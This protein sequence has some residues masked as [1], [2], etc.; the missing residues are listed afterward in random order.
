MN[1]ISSY[2]LTKNSEKY[3]SK[4]LDE[5][6]VISDEIFIIDSGSEDRTES[7]AKSYRKTTFCYNEFENFKDQRL[8]AEN[9]CSYDMILFL[10]SDEIPDS[11]FIRSVKEIKK[12]GFKHDAYR[13]QRS[14]NVLGK[15][16]HCIYPISSPDHP[17]RLYNKKT[18]TFND[19]Q[20][21]HE[22]L[23]GYNSLGTI[24]GVIRHITFE[25]KN[26]LNRKLQFYTNIAAQDLINKG[27][28]IN[29]FKIIFNPI[30]SFIKWYFIKQGFKDGLTGVILG[31]YAHDYTRKKYVKGKHLQAQNKLL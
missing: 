14:W 24:K 6:T 19:S 20:L 18:T 23:T 17:I 7:I 5:L 1:Q 26:E 30:A 21:V 13:A 10:D 15:N 29:S 25:T 22:S 28:K 9:L 4:I 11:E 12:N 27:K 2:I 16:I 31:K 3:L 8:F